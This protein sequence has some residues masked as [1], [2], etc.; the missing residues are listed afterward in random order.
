[1]DEDAERTPESPAAIDRRR[2]E[3]GEMSRRFQ[4]RRRELEKKAEA[5]P[6]DYW[7]ETHDDLGQDLSD[8]KQFTA[9]RF[10]QAIEDDPHDLEIGEEPPESRD[11]FDGLFL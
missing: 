10:M 6:W 7:P 4:E 5:D 8:G 3:V 9:G 1:M 11:V 2:S